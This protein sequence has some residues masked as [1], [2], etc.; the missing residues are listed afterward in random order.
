MTSTTNDDADVRRVIGDWHSAIVRGDLEGVLAAH[1]DSE[2]AGSS[3][4][5]ITRSRTRD[6]HR[7]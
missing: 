3:R 2:R 1:T 4:T 5:N 7:D 6:H